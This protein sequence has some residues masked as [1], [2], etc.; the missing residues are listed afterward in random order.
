MFS[1]D[2]LALLPGRPVVDRDGQKFGKVLDV[3]QLGAAPESFASISSVVLGVRASLV[4]LDA[5]T[6]D[7]ST[8]RVPYTKDEVRRAPRIEVDGELDRS[9][10]DALLGHYRSASALPDA[11]TTVFTVSVTATRAAGVPITDDEARS[12]GTAL[13][14]AIGELVERTSAALAGDP[15]LTSST[16][17]A[18][19]ELTQEPEAPP[20]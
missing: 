19:I 18:Q 13:S 7:G 9:D 1:E 16:A 2:A 8:L 14:E 20:S 11:A 4:P 5:A 3:Y 15:T 6:L 12:V 17:S 10:A